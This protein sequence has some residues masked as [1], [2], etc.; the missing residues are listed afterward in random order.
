MG[1]QLFTKESRSTEEY[2]PSLRHLRLVHPE[3]PA[4]E[5]EVKVR[6]GDLVTLSIHFLGEPGLYVSVNSSGIPAQGDEVRDENM[7]SNNI[8]GLSLEMELWDITR[9]HRFPFKEF[10]ALYHNPSLISET[11]S[12][13]CLVRFHGQHFAIRDQRAEICFEFPVIGS[14]HKKSQKYE[15]ADL[16]ASSSVATLTFGIPRCTG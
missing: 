8:N 11:G 15:Y 7:P 13:E 6:R 4:N 14:G 16:Y 5:N 3:P 10:C 12:C 1:N 2:I 9:P